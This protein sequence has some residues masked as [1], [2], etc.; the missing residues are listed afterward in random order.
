MDEI[1]VRFAPSPTGALHIGGARTALLNWLFARSQG[2]KFILRIEDT[3]QARST[4]HSESGI[5]EGL[6][7]L[8]LDWDEGPDIGGPYG[9]YRQS[10]RLPLYKKYLDYLVNTGKAYYCFCSTEEIEAQRKQADQKK[11]PYRYNRRCCALS[12]E[13]IETNLFQHKPYV[14]R[15]KAPDSGETRV[16]DLVRGDISFQNELLDDFILMKSDGLPTYQFAVVVDDAL[17]KISHVIRAEEHLANTPK[18]L[19]LYEALGFTPPIFAHVSMILS[20]DRSKLS[21]RHGATSVQEFAQNGYLPQALLNYLVLLGWSPGNGADILTLQEMID[22]FD[23]SNLSKSAAVY[24]IE[25]I[26]WLN[27]HYIAEESP[28]TLLKLLRHLPRQ[29]PENCF[30]AQVLP[31]LKLLQSRLK[32]LTDFANQSFYFFHEVTDYEGKGIQK[33]FAQPDALENLAAV[34]EVVR[35][36]LPFDEEHLEKNLR[37]EAN[38]RSIKAAALIHPTRL[39]LTGRTNSPGIFEVMCLLG[40]DICQRRIQSALNFIRRFD[41]KEFK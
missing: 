22:Q 33:Y 30:D 26:N 27:A 31:I 25:K 4:T 6:R 17:M 40:S 36:T 20:P 38:R 9:P 24:D 12:K 14:I 29:I 5:I 7:W 19:L 15:L 32:K 18:Q 8:N 21:K 3:D 23:L 28:E 11:I 10:E 34:L 35:A 13:E 16:H 1:R 37:E 41:A 39:A 2:G